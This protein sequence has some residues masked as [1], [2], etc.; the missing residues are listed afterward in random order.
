MNQVEV[1]VQEV[2][3]ARRAA[4]DMGVPQLLGEGSGHCERQLYAKPE[5]GICGPDTTERRSRSLICKVHM[6]DSARNL[7]LLLGLL[8]LIGFG[9]TGARAN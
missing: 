9:Q 2:R 1:D 5:G 4:H 6:A 3:F 8:G 7:V